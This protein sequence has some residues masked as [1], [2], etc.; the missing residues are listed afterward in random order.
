MGRAA[1]GNAAGLACVLAQPRRLPDCRPRSPGPCRKASPPARSPGRLPERFVVNDIGNYG[2]AGSVDLLVPITADPKASG[3]PPGGTAPIRAQATWL[4][5]ADICIPG[6]AELA[7]ALPV[8][9]APSG[10]DPAQASLFA[11]SR[12]RLP[13]P[14]GFA[15]RVAASGTDLTLRLPAA[16]LAGI[17]NPTVSFFPTEPNLIDAAAEPRT[18]MSSDGLDLLLKRATGPTASRPCRRASTACWCCAAP[19]AAERSYAVS[20]PVDRRGVGPRAGS[21]RRRA[22]SRV[23]ASAAAGL[24]RRRRS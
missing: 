10:P 17:A 3:P 14:A 18:R 15:T 8:A 11:A 19:T 21:I 7:L 20:A 16:A 9:A 4:A 13:L 22:R 24:C 2:Y 12:E 5:C 1:S 23:V 6:G